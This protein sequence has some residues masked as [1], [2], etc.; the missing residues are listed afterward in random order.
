MTESYS[1]SDSFSRLAKPVQSLCYFREEEYREEE[2]SEALAIL[3]EGS[4]GVQVRHR[5][6]R[7]EEQPMK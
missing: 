2:E 1:S 4:D 7:E 6:G 3:L 5:L